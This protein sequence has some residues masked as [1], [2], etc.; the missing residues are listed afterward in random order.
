M[1][2]FQPL[3]ILCLALS[4]CQTIVAQY[5]D[6]LLFTAELDGEFLSNA[7]TGRGL[8]TMLTNTSFDTLCLDLVVGNLTNSISSINIYEVGTG[9]VVIDLTSALNNNRVQ[10]YLTAS[11]FNSSNWQQN[12]MN[13]AYY[14]GVDVGDASLMPAGK[15]MFQNHA[16]FHA[17]LDTTQQVHTVTGLTGNA[18]ALAVFHF[19]PYDLDITYNIITLGLTGPI[20]AAHLHY[21][22]AGVA[23]GVAVDLG[24]GIDGNTVSGVAAA[25]NDFMD[26][27]NAGSIYVNVHTATNTAGEIRGQAV[28]E[29]RLA[30]EAVI[31]TAQQVHDVTNANTEGIS[32]F[33][34][35][36]TM[37]TL[38]IDAYLDSLS[39]NLTAAHI[40]EGPEG[41]AGGVLLDLSAL[42]NGNR[43]N[44]T[45]TSGVDQA[46]ISK[47]MT[48][49]AYVNFHT[50]ANTAGEARGQ[51]HKMARDGNVFTLEGT[52]QTPAISV[53]GYG[54]GFTSIDP[55]QK[56]VYFSYVA[57]SLTGTPTGIHFHQAASGSSGAVVFDMANL[58]T[59]VGNTVIGSGAWYQNGTPAFDASMVEAFRTNEIYLNIHTQTNS[60]G[61]LRGQAYRNQ[62]VCDAFVTSTHKIGSTIKSLTVYPNPTNA[63]LNIQLENT[64]TA[65]YQLRLMN[66]LGE[67][68]QN[69]TVLLNQGSNF[70]QINLNDYQKGVY[71]LVIDNGESQQTVKVM[72]Y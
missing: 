9:N 44:G 18:N 20:T 13:G 4:F 43:V 11:D 56:D 58:F 64:T 15:I 60:A 25:P 23:G 33:A 24:S 68:V 10:A 54:N 50:A 52:Q 35:N 7:P 16:L 37:D 26:S 70:L 57:D 39:G 38:W 48:G 17:W 3:I 53:A 40:H 36:I 32:Y 65:Q 41:V 27:L 69:Q 66:V 61:E 12:L 71:F 67:T 5:N 8:A 63:E 6:R 1:K 2:K 62:T 34:T 51:I 55:Y 22:Q 47:L 30:F 19:H 49:Q 29:E 59:S 28:V 46:L 31:D 72:K 42:I 14:L 21:G 45:I